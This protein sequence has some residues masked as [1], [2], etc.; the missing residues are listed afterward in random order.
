M[1]IY[2][3]R[4][5]KAEDSPPEG[6][7][8]SRRLT[9][10]G[11][12]EIVGIGLWM[13][14]QDLE[15]DLIAASPLARAQETAA[16]IAGVLDCKKRPLSWDV[17]VPGSEPDAVCHEISRHAKSSAILLVGHEPLLSSLIS[18]IISGNEDAGIAMTKGALAK[19]RDVSF[20]ERP[21]GE[22]HWLLTAK[23]MNF[24]K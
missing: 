22:L 3:L 5:G 7:D 10:K 2:I 17:L 21:S 6:G 20:T 12:E 16:I 4:H 19:I 9:K 13:A 8:A 1:D 23:Q 11:S 24:R 18:R 15:F 14:A